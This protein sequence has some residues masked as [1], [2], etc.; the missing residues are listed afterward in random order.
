MWTGNLSGVHEEGK[1]KD[2]IGRGER[3]DGK[4]TGNKAAS[5]SGLRAVGK[6]RL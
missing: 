2:R 5:A 4:S 6:G 1:R 3:R